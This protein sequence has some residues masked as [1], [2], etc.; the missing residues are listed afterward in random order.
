MSRESREEIRWLG[1]D[2]GEE[3]HALVLLGG[4]GEV[5]ASWEPVR[6]DPEELE[7]LLRQIDEQVGEARLRLVLEM[8]QG[9]ARALY[10]AALALGLEVWGA[11]PKA[12]A[13]FRESEGQPRKD[14]GWD[15]YLLAR[16]GFVGSGRC[17]PMAEAWPEER[18]LCRLT[19]LQRQLSERHAQ[20]MNRLRSRLL[21][22]HPELVRRASETPR[23]Q[24]QRLLAV[25]ARFPALSGLE[26]AESS[27][28]DARLRTVGARQ[29]R[30]EAQAL[31]RV[32]G[33]IQVGPEEQEVLALE[34]EILVEEI[35]RLRRARREVDRRLKGYV[36]LHPLGGKL[37]E[38]P[39]VGPLVAGVLLGEILPLTRHLSEG[40]VATYA[41]LTPLGRRSGKSRGR[42][43][44]ARGTNK[45]VLR[46]LYQSAMAAVR[47]SALD[48]A[49]YRKKRAEYAGHPAVHAAATLALGRQRIKLMYKLLTTE[50]RYDKEI[51]IRSHL[52]RQ[53]RGA[54]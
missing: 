2:C 4:S 37:L 35:E 44:L 23:W 11:S 1:C 25:L 53:Q 13:S 33:E 40:A 16:M 24:S 30:R 34:L 18:R 22:L 42:D 6:N 49:Y 26:H 46:A 32:A 7:G 27:E 39:G 45:H 38:M 52:R 50:E 48:R 43:Q 51:L 12:L 21:E 15:G 54:A 10:R 3:H 19:R 41:G 5:A 31:R 8:S 9:C 47:V 17:R 20:A 28:L 29:R 36:E 14:D